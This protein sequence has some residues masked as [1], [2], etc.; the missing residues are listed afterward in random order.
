MDVLCHSC[1]FSFCF[2]YQN[3]ASVQHRYAVLSEQFDQLH[4]KSQEIITTLQQE[5]DKKIVECEELK[6][7]VSTIMLYWHSLSPYNIVY[8]C[9]VCVHVFWTYV[10][11]CMCTSVA[12]MMIE[13]LA[14]Q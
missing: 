11:V 6:P 12:E 1:F 2:A 5:R 14:S 7:Q 13:T 10:H 9:P 4:A 3:H 8:G